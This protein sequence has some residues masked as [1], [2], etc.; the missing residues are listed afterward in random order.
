MEIVALVSALISGVGLLGVIELRER[1]TGALQ[2]VEL[3]FG[4][5]LTMEM[6]QSMIASVAGLPSSSVVKID[7]YADGG[8]IRHFLAAEQAIVDSLRSQWRG[9]A[10]SLRIDE[11][12]C[13]A[14]EW[15]AGAVL[16]LGGAHPVLRSDATSEAVASLL[17][18]LQPLGE[19]EALLWRVVLTPATRPALPEPATREQRPPAS[20]LQ[21]LVAGSRPPRPD[22]LRALRAKY[23]GPV[24]K[25][26]V[27]VAVQS[28][29]PKRS[30]HLL[31]RMA[32]VA[33]SRRGGYGGLVVRR[34]GQRQLE[35]LL[36]RRSLRGGDIYS[37]SELAPLLGL[38]VDGP[39]LAG[40]SLGTAPV[41]MPARDVPTQGRVLAAS[42]WPGSNRVLAQPVTGGLSHSV[43]VGP[44]GVGKSSLAL[45]LIKQ[46][47]EAGRGLL[48]V[49]GKGDLAS[50]VLRAIP[51]HRIGDVIV[52]DPARSDLPIPGLQV[53]GRGAQNSA[54]LTADLVLGIL[55]DLYADS[56]G[57]LS[58]RWFR[59]G[60]ILL[61]R[62]PNA[63]LAD[64]PF[65]FT[66][67]AYRRRLLAGL[68][69]PMAQQVWASFEAMGAPERAHQLAAPLNKIEE[70][71]GRKVVRA[72]LAQNTAQAKLD[73]RN[74]LATGKVV[75]V[76]LAAG[77][78]GT[79]SARLIGALIV[80]Q[81]FQ[82]VQS[83]AALSLAAR[84]PFFA[85]VD[86]PKVL[87]DVNVP[88]DSLYELA[89]G[90]GVGITLSIQ[91]FAQLPNDLRA[92]AATNAS[93]LI[94]FRQ[95][96]TDARILAQELP[97]VS[98]EGL[99]NLGKYEAIM[100]IGL[101]P[102]DVTAP[103]SGRT[104]PPAPA[105]SDPEQVRRASAERYG[106]DPAEVDAALAGRHKIGGATD[107]PVG[108]SRR[109]S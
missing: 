98:A 1:P 7:T 102:G 104:F 93:T 35:R 36:M 41:L 3:R 40:L 43:F 73:M 6:V 51:D 13:P 66:H 46:D 49:D 74:V 33:R 34:R 5:D 96:A 15:S 32:S 65:V 109:S 29:H 53:F 19:H 4:P 85:Y 64:F 9:V 83:R 55:A 2:T 94:A 57:P 18:A 107:A 70:I 76:P 23:T 54:E 61:A 72:V 58:A 26:V 63:T 97:G 31:S 11:Q 79:P 105:I 21:G 86:E 52:V 30:A 16:R 82:A 89:R 67:D 103:V 68:D 78:I 50:D 59:A 80:H 84:R 24:V 88:L 45:G 99:Q 38:P 106:T 48:L 101:G 92:A 87:G 60:L 20:V 95:T 39:Q 69:D 56:W 62:D 47:L 71:I 42:T 37:A 81:L 108:R 77:Q 90:M 8:G 10:P 25:A 44:S 17:G 12:D 28:G 100:R 75:I 14:A 27:L 91:S 22:H